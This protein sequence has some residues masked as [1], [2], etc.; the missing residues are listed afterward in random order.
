M[1]DNLSKNLDWKCRLATRESEKGR[2]RGEI[3]T[4]ISKR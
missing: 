2:A 4:G 1:K 3:I